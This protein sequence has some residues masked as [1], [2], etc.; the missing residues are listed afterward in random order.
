MA[1]I[2]S[3]IP[4]DEAAA[5]IA[6]PAQLGI[7]SL[8]GFL[9]A[10]TYTEKT[11][12]PGESSD[13]N[14]NASA[15]NI[16]VNLGRFFN[17]PFNCS[18]GAGYSRTFLD[19]GSII[20]L[21]GSGDLRELLPE[22]EKQGNYTIGVGVSWLVKLGIGFNFKTLTSEV[23]V[24]DSIGYRSVTFSTNAHD[25][26]AMIQIPVNDI[27]S[28]FADQPLTISPDLKPLLDINLGYAERNIGNYLFLPG[29]ILESIY[30][31]LPRTAT[32]GLNFAIGIKTVVEKRDWKLFSFVWAREAEDQLL[33]N[34][35]VASPAGSSSV[36]FQ[37]KSGIGDIE[38]IDNL[39]LGRSYGKVD[40]RKGWQ[41]QLADFLF[42][43]GGKFEGIGYSYN[44][45]GTSVELNGFLKLF[46]ALDIVDINDVPFAFLVDHL[47]LQYHF[48]EYT[49]STNSGMNGTTF[50]AINIVIK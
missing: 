40:L 39:I 26:G 30:Q 34:L 24:T 44:T 42:I 17:T 11:P 50:E 31:P 32:I 33:L 21:H 7:F 41:V 2:A 3:S 49:N 47:D 14:L 12:W 37:Y 19:L 27:A 29:A 35:P 36:D 5:T 22:W 43:R 15:V 4:S 9:N 6:N 1:G 46:A 13:L 48:S 28:Y 20:W 23:P 38:P 18:I 10:S 45:F 16:G 25:F 8:N